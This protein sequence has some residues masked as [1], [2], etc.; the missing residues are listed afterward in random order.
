MSLE[1]IAPET[2]VSN[3]ITDLNS[4][5]SRVRNILTRPSVQVIEAT[6]PLSQMF[7]YTT[8]LRSISQGRASYTMKFSSYEAVDNETMNRVMGRS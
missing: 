7:G 4:R 3:V 6:A 5:N 1:V 2:F 8:K